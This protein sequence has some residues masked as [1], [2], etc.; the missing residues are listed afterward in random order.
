MLRNYTQDKPLGYQQIAGLVAATA[1]T[2]PAGA[3]ICII[4]PESQAVRWRDDGVAPTATVGYPL[5][6]GAE[7]E[8]TTQ[9]MAGIQF[10]QQAATA[11]LNITYYGAPL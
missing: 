2:V 7:L 9:N 10:I 11:T 1:L 3:V 4:T 5:S 8:C 6:V